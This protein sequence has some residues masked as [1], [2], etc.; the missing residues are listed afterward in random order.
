[1]AVMGTGFCV[2]GVG[3]PFLTRFW[4]PSAI[5]RTGLLLTVLGIL[6]DPGRQWAA[7][8]LLVLGRTGFVVAVAYGV[9]HSPLFGCRGF[10]TAR[11]NPGHEYRRG[12]PAWGL[13]SIA[14][15]YLAAT[16][17]WAPIGLAV[18]FLILSWLVSLTLRQ[19][20]PDADILQGRV[21]EP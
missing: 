21:K 8:E 10:H 19:P 7:A 6:G 9:H 18:G 3:L 14:A 20:S 13:V 4:S 17:A 12:Q 11:S 15:G 5:T 2:S 1:M 16:G